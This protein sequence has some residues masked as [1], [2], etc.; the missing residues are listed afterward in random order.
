MSTWLDDGAVIDRYVRSLLVRTDNTRR[1]YRLELA[2][3]QRF[4]MKRSD[5]DEPNGGCVDGLG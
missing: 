1:L 3:F 2:A 5:R 4:M